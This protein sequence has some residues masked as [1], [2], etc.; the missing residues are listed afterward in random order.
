M[1]TSGVYT[2]APTAQE[3]CNDIL[4][5]LGVIGEGE[6]ANHDQVQTIIRAINI[7]VAQYSGPNSVGRPG[8]IMWQRETGSINLTQGDYLYTL[9]P[10]G[11][12]LSIQVPVD[13]LLAYVRDSDNADLGMH[14]IT[15]DKYEAIPNKTEPGTPYFYHYEKRLDVGNLYV[16]PAPDATAAGYYL[17]IIYRQPIERIT[18]GSQELDIEEY[19]LRAIKFN[20]A[21]D[22]SPV[23]GADISQLQADLASDAKSMINTFYPEDVNDLFFQPEYDGD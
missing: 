11:G 14:P 16:Y 21:I 9:K 2:Y 23:F 19:W 15:R 1:A 7:W 4:A 12:D 17:R 6:A 8:N 5:W 10:S 18:S 20:V 22:V 3:I 13:I